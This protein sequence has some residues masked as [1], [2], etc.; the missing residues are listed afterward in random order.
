MSAGA[1]LGELGSLTDKGLG[2]VRRLLRLLAVTGRLSEQLPS[3][4]AVAQTLERAAAA[5]PAPKGSRAR[6]QSS[7]GSAPPSIDLPGHWRWARFTDVAAIQSNLVSPKDFT[8]HPHVAPDNIE[9]GTGRLLEFRTVKEDGVH[10]N[11][12]L[13]FPGQ[14]VYSKIRPNLS[15]AVI[16]DFEGLCSADM[17]PLLPLI[18][19]AYLLLFILSEP[20]LGQVVSSDNRL[21]MPKV[22]QQQLGAS[23]VAVPPLPEQKRIVEKVDQ[24]MALCDELEDRQKKKRETS[25]QLNKAALNAV[26]TAPNPK[27]LKD[28]W[29][30]V[31]DHFEVLYDLPENV[32]EL[33]QTILQLAVMGKLVRQD[34]KD[35]PAAKLLERATS[36]REALLNG[37]KGGGRT[38][39]AA[40]A[41]LAHSLPRTWVECPL[42]ALAGHIVDGTHHTPKYVSKGVDFI[43]AK[44]IKRG[45]IV[46]DGCR[47]ITREEFDQLRIRCAPKL[48][49]VLITKSG[50]IGDVAIVRTNHQFTLFESVALVPVVPCVSS[51]YVALAM[52]VEGGGSFGKSR[53]KGMAVRHLHLVDLRTLPVGL[54]P[55]LEQ[56]RIVR[57]VDQLLALCDDLEAKLNQSREH[58]QKL[59]QAVVESLVA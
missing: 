41:S 55:R 50:S 15:K 6:E 46:F 39:S 11:K 12:H 38:A 31:Q 29:K 54:P 48:G 51:E 58:G 23:W 8:H 47:Q 18:D 7:N 4:E 43:S 17:Y 52:Q 56:D 1:L 2:E 14:I 20:F 25:V 45:R 3:D 33:R 10:S 57:K 40:A 24:L 35:E 42:A 26:V 16:V 34:P 30:R 59:M 44:D 53:Q 5:R 36:E 9:K 19:R 13:F 27:V 28:S 22:N 32:K 21:A 49:D 37:R